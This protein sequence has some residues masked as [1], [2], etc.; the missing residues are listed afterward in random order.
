[1]RS[2]ISKPLPA[3]VAT[4]EPTLVPRVLTTSHSG[5]KDT[6]LGLLTF[7]CCA[8]AS[9]FLPES[10]TCPWLRCADRFWVSCCYVPSL[11]SK[12]L[13]QQLHHTLL[14]FNSLEAAFFFIKKKKESKTLTRRSLLRF[15]HCT[16]VSLPAPRCCRVKVMG[17]ERQQPEFC[18]LT[19][20][21]EG[22]LKEA[23][24]LEPGVGGGDSR[25]R[26]TS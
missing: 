26:G 16:F 18:L 21:R 10:R 12:N 15:C 2:R 3:L 4:T 24:L 6:T 22:L 19:T 9:S 8:S 5:P 17:N 1:M 23:G 7:A 13:L 14:V 20:S 25:W 11:S